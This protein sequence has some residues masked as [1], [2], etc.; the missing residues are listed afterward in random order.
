MHWEAFVVRSA[1]WE[2]PINHDVLT[3]GINLMGLPHMA[4]L[5]LR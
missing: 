1:F 4:A 3:R 5:L 2:R